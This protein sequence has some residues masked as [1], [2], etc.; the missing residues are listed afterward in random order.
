M[1]LAGYEFMMCVYDP[2]ICFVYVLGMFSGEVF[3]IE[4]NIHRTIKLGFIQ[5]TKI[6]VYRD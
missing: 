3:I 1:V 6:G 2:A 4:D 5:I